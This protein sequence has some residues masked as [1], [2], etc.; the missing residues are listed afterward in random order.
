MTPPGNA[1]LRAPLHHGECRRGGEGGR[2]GGVNPNGLFFCLSFFFLFNG[3]VFNCTTQGK[4]IAKQSCSCLFC[5]P[6][7]PLH[8]HFL[9]RITKKKPQLLQDKQ[10]TQTRSRA[11]GQIIYRETN[12]ICMKK[13]KKEN[14][15]EC[16]MFATSSR[17]NLKKKRENKSRCT[18]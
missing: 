3:C 16:S 14:G 6:S 15:A 2:E 8:L 1:L 9:K 5:P 17:K 11:L 7:P 12:T 13:K 18:S 10:Q 4:L